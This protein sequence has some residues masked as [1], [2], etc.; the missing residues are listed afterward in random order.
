MLFNGPFNISGGTQ[1]WLPKAA[2]AAGI[3]TL[4]YVAT[5]SGTGSGSSTFTQTGVSF[6]P[7]FTSRRIIVAM[8]SGNISSNN[9]S[10]ATIGGVSATIH[11]GSYIAPGNVAVAEVYFFS[12]VVPTGETGTITITLSGGT[13]ANIFFAVHITGDYDLA[14]GGPTTAY[15]EDSAAVSSLTT[16][17]ATTSGGFIIAGIGWDSGSFKSTVTCTGDATYTAD[18][19]SSSQARTWYANSVLTDANNS[20]TVAWSAGSC[21]AGLGLLGWAP[22]GSTASYDAA[23]VSLFS[24]FSTPATS[25]RKGII[26]TCIVALKAAG[27]WTKLDVLYMFAAADSQAS[28]MNW[29]TS[30]TYTATEINGPITCTAERGYTTNGSNRRVQTNFDP[31]TGTNQYVQDSAQ[32]S[33]WSRTSGTTSSSGNGINTTTN[34]TAINLRNGSDQATARANNNAATITV[35]SVTDGSGFYTV[36]RTASNLT[37]LYKTGAALGSSATASGAFTSGTVGRVGEFGGGFAAREWASCA[38][39]SGLTGAEAALFNAA[40]T[41]YMV[42]VGAASFE[43]ETNTLAA[44]FTTPPT[45]TRKALINAC[46]KSLKDAGVWSK[47]DAF[48]V[49]AAADSQAAKI[50]WK[51][52]GTYN[53]S[54][55]SSPSFTADSGYTG[56]GTSSYLNTGF[57]PS[58]AS[59][60]NFV[61][62]SAHVSARNRVSGAGSNS[63]RLVGI[64][65]SGTVGNR[66]LLIP[67]IGSAQ[68]FGAVNENSSLTPANTN[69]DGHFVVNR[70]GANDKQ[71]Y[72]NGAS[73]TTSSANASAG[74]NNSQLTLLADGV[75]PDFSVLQIASASIGSSLSSTEVAALY[76][77]ELA[78]MNAVGAV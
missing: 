25:V 1:E 6:G 2:A 16:D 64:D 77:A 38:A 47:L 23:S 44:A 30:G 29:K 66:V 13:S 27:V 15:I 28:L 60:P 50:N 43:T 52:P 46:I 58:T 72:R 62:N 67:R 21:G 59:S 48:Y 33:V 11:R 63:D 35:S 68:F 55:V 42:A 8:P 65:S 19:T 37:T 4:V 32:W 74:V 31:A 53:A 20:A 36:S 17:V 54:E 22:S 18:G 34:N 49:F 26:D 78:Y 24:A 5:A 61:Q 69:K 7:A 51:N 71:L 45:A 73:V 56:N 14:G 75:N 57:T 10:T 9:L 39:G 70:S 40:V 76:A 41:N 3:V 12:A